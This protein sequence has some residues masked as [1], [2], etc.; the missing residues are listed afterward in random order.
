[1]TAA[2][3]A[4]APATTPATTV[5][6]G[7]LIGML[8]SIHAAVRRDLAR[9]QESLSAL[10]AADV[11]ERPAGVEPLQRYWARFTAM[12]HHHHEVEDDEVW[13]HLEGVFGNRAT[14]VLNAMLAEHDD[15]V[16]G[17]ARATTA[18]EKLRTDTDDEQIRRALEAVAT[19]RDVVDAHLAHEESAAVPFIAAD[20]DA[21]FWDAFQARRQQDEGPDVFLP[22]VLDEAPTHVVATVE[23]QLPPPVRELLVGQWR[24]VPRPRPRPAARGGRLNDAR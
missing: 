24:P 22:W 15:V 16:A 20:H 4:G 23:G 11:A 13:P 7:P 18:L 19:F 3:A 6:N 5:A 10:A 8:L 9:T 1:M 12:L 21:A 2:T 17:E 14:G